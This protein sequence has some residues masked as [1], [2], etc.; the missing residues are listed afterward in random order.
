MCIHVAT[1]FIRKNKMIFVLFLSVLLI[2]IV[3]AVLGRGVNGNDSL[4]DGARVHFHVNDTVT[5]DEN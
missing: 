5:L 3:V 1:L 4:G 2:V